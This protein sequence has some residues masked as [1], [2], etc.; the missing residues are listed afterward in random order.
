M[1]YT[2]SAISFMLK[3]LRS[4][5]IFAGSQRPLN[6]ARTDALQNI[7]SAITLAASGYLGLKP[8]IREVTVYSYDTLFRANRASMVSASS[9]RTYDSPNFPSIATVGEHI[10]IQ[11]HLVRAPDESKML[12]ANTKV[13]A[14]VV[15]LDVFP[16]MRPAIINGLARNVE[17]AREANNE[18]VPIRGVLLRTYGMGTAPTSSSVLDALQK[19]NESDIVVMNVTQARSGRISHGQD[20][21]SLRL[22]EQGVISGVDMTAEAAYAKMVV[23]LSQV[24]DFH[25]V[26][27]LLQLERAGEQSQSIFHIHFDA[28]QTREDDTNPGI[29]QAILSPRPVNEV[30]LLRSHI[31]R[32]SYI[33]LRLLGLE[34]VTGDNKP[35]SRTIELDVSL[36]D[37]DGPAN[38]EVARLKS[39]LLRWVARGRRTINM[40]YDITDAKDRLLS[41]D[42]IPSTRVRLRTNEMVRWKRASIAIFTTVEDS[43]Y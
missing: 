19:L 31:G 5:V 4:P 13:D 43:V 18:N 41:L 35:V 25:E 3:G 12:I 38:S 6:F 14:E 22:F 42:K 11:S 30:H 7:F 40:A 27:D 36:V 1:A 8:I 29:F 37:P 33:Q 17:R 24:E 10:E 20:P 32:V 23:L 9:Y 16:G 34:P 21:V 2:A 15:I 39:D 26:S 28:N